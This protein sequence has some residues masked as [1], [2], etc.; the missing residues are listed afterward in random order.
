[1]KYFKAL[2]FVICL[3]TSSI[4][5]SAAQAAE[6]DSRYLSLEQLRATYGDEAGKIALIDGLEVYYK[7]EGQGPVIF[8]VHGSQSSNRTWDGVASRLTDR[9]RVIRYDIPPQGLSGPVSDEI[10]ASLQAEELAE[11]LLEQLGVKSLTFVGVSSG[12]TLGVYLA[13]RRPDLVERLIVSN[14]P[15]DTVT[16]THL[17]PSTEFDEAKRIAEETGFR[18]RRFWDAFLS[19]FS[20]DP[21]RF[22]EATRAAFY[23][24]NRRA[25]EPNLISLV[26]KVVDQQK[27]KAAM[28]SVKAPTLLIWGGSDFLLPPS[29]AHA[30]ATYLSSTQVSMV[31]MPDVGHYPPFE[32]PA[33]FADLVRMYI[34][35][36]VPQ[37]R[38]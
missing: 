7:D 6:P 26:A 30:L 34:E 8:M 2:A 32:A 35:S 4:T 25:P 15:A 24:F 38:R 36:A 14:M 13:A 33:R 5:F 31:M 11:K 19:Y 3:V 17:P 23:D 1:M 21:E 20:G 18:D 27:A 22:D 28:K 16:T 37:P 29:A 10:A 12:G 9:Y